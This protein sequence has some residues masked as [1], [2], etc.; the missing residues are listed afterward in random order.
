MKLTTPPAAIDVAATGPAAKPNTPYLQAALSLAQELARGGPEWWGDDLI[1]ETPATA[2]VI[3]RACGD[4]LYG[5]TA[6]I[7]AFLVHAG[8]AGGDDSV[9]RLGGQVLSAAVQRALVAGD[10]GGRGGR[11][12]G[13]RREAAPRDLS[14]YTGEAG[15]ALAAHEAACRT[16][17]SA[18]RAQA[19]ALAESVAQAARTEP[20]PRADDL[21]GGPAGTLLALLALART[22]TVAARHWVPAVARLADALCNRAA[23]QPLGL[24]WPDRDASGVA[25]LAADPSG[26]FNTLNPYGTFGLFGMD[27]ADSADSADGTDGTDGTDG[28]G[29][30]SATTIACTTPGL[31]GMAHGASGIAWALDEAGA[32]LLAPAASAARWRQVAAQA[33]LFE[34]SWFDA[35][36]AA[37]PDLRE[38]DPAATSAPPTACAWCHGGI[39]IGAVRWRRYSE[40]GD[41]A[42][43]AEASACQQ[44]ARLGL[45]A[46]QA[47]LREGR[48][49]DLTPCHGLAG[50][51]ELLLLAHEAT[52]LPEHLQAARR[53]GDFM[54]RARQ[55]RG[56]WGSGLVG[57]EDV[58]GLMVGRAGI[59][60]TLLRLHDVRAAPSPLLP[61]HTLG[62]PALPLK[63]PLKLSA[64][65]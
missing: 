60:T 31:C 30:P 46:A 34:S 53:V 39:G 14:L 22:E 9:C 16:S 8:L 54:L 49:P 25:R 47:T 51:A 48:L 35:A 50:S 10:G 64:S 41:V 4:G 43:L 27:G 7:G 55:E 17:D 28:A 36:R 56:A 2:K 12:G 23:A 1:G 44:G 32:W 26:T 40:Q 63:V 62:P 42:D 11:G 15:I 57:A 5:G 52:A 13:G 38:L 58:P 45:A 18:L 19:L 3:R 24:H 20:L 59:G 6:G 61:G 65:A 33:R 29:A 37:W 21:I